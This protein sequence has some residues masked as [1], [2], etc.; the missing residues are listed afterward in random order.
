MSHGNSPRTLPLDY[1]QALKSW[2]VDKGFG[3]AT[4]KNKKDYGRP[5]KPEKKRAPS[6]NDL[7]PYMNRPK[8]YGK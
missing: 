1:S 3:R 5:S 2:M 6:L 4:R 7:A 8:N